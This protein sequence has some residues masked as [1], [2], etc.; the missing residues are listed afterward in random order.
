VV[1]ARGRHV[2]EGTVASLCEQAGRDDFEDAFV[3]LA[4]GL[5]E[6]HPQ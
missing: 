4:F 1:V 5:G 2:A 3:Q 6:G